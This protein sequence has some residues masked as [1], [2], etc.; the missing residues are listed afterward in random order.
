MRK[1]SMLLGIFFCFCLPTVWGAPSRQGSTGGILLPSA[2]VLRK[3]QASLGFFRQRGDTR[4]N[5][6]LGIDNHWEISASEQTGKTAAEV[7][8]KYMLQ[9]EGILQPGIAV[10]VDDIGGQ[11]KRS[12]YAVV[13]KGLPFGIRLHTGWGKG[14]YGGLFLGAEKK[15]ITKA[16]PGM[17]PDTSLFVEDD[18]RVA[19]VGLR[20][21]VSRGSKIE[22]GRRDGHSFIGF[23]YN[24]Y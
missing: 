14:Q 11:E 13:S 10:G 8:L 2:D 12:P 22:F 6:A 1:I 23:S 5:F 18:G 21:S 24:Y 20:M 4:V 15:L 19:S 9:P 17:F 3:E 7:N 16:K